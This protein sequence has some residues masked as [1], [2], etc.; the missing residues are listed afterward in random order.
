MARSSG[1]DDVD[2]EAEVTILDKSLDR[3]RQIDQQYG[4]RVNTLY[5]NID[6]IEQAVLD[7]DLVIGAVLV[8][9]AVAHTSTFA[10][11]N[12]TAPS[13]LALADKGCSRR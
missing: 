1:A 11:N 10:L 2:L 8:P 9:G 12:A 6:T 3:L 13:V 4:R 5:A 7:A